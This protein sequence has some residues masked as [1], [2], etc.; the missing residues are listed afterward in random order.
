MY[1]VIGDLNAR[2]G[3][4]RTPF[5]ANKQLAAQAEYT[6]SP[7]PIRT[8]NSNAKSI[9]RMLAPFLVLLNGLKHGT[10]TFEA[11]LTF[12]QKQRWVSELDSCLASPGC[13]PLI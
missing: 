11:A 1:I 8:P 7:D 10:C 4:E 13:I 2:F 3:N 12:R 6:A 9:T 5:I